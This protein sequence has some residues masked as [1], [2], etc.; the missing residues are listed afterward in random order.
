MNL[1]AARL[2]RSS[3]TGIVAAVVLVGASSGACA[4]EARSDIN[5]TLREW[6]VVPANM[7]APAGQVTFSV[8]NE[9]TVDHEFMVVRSDLGLTELPTKADGSLDEEGQGVEVVDATNAAEH[10]DEEH[11]KIEPGAEKEFAYELTEGKY[12]LICNLIEE[13]GGKTER[14]HFKLGM[15]LPFTV[16]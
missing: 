3:V 16:T 7:S 6:S 4:G 15:R 12:V 10:G 13:E 9:G 1:R 2:R 11:E 14:A 5:V 8:S